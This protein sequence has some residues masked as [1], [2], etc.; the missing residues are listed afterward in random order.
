M[1]EF[2][3]DL[4]AS[5]KLNELKATIEEVRNKISKNEIDLYEEAFKFENLPE[6][7]VIG[8]K[9]PSI[10]TLRNTEKAQLIEKNPE[11]STSRE[12]DRI[13]EKGESLRKRMDKAKH[14][15]DFTKIFELEED[16]IP[17]YDKDISFTDEIDFSDT[18]K[19]AESEKT[20]D[21]PTTLTSNSPEKFITLSPKDEIPTFQLYLLIERASKLL[22]ADGSC[23]DL[24]ISYKIFLNKDKFQT[25]I[26]WNYSE[27]T[28]INYKMLFPLV[29]NDESLSKLYSGI[30]PLEI[31]DKT[32]S[33]DSLL[34][35]VK[36]PLSLFGTALSA[37]LETFTKTVYPFIAIDEYK[38]IN[39]LKTGKDIGYLK[40]LL[41][42]GTPS[43]IN[44]LD[45]T[46]SIDKKFEDSPRKTATFKELN[47]DKKIEKV[48]KIEKIEKVEKIEKIENSAID[49]ID[50]IALFLNQGS[51]KNTLNDSNG[52]KDCKMIDDVSF[53]GGSENKKTEL[54]K[55]YEVKESFEEITLK[56]DEIRLYE[57]QFDDFQEKPPNIKQESTKTNKIQD[58]KIIKQPQISINLQKKSKNELI[59]NLKNALKISHINLEE[60]LKIADKYNLGFLHTLS[61]VNFFEKL[62]L[63]IPSEEI[64]DF[65]TLVVK[66]N[67]LTSTHRRVLFTDLYKILDIVPE[68]VKIQNSL[69]IKIQNMPQQ[70]RPSPYKKVFVKYEKVIEPDLTD[71]NLVKINNLPSQLSVLPNNTILEKS[72]IVEPIKEINKPIEKKVENKIEEKSKEIEKSLEEEDF[73]KIYQK[74]LENMRTLESLTQNFGSWRH[75]KSDSSPAKPALAANYRTNSLKDELLFFS[76][77]IEN[78]QE[79]SSLKQFETRSHERK[80]TDLS[81]YYSSSINNSEK[82]EY[83]SISSLKSTISSADTSKINLYE[84][85]IIPTSIY[86]SSAER[87]FYNEKDSF[88]S[89]LEKSGK[90][91]SPKL[92]KV[93]ENNLK[94]NSLSTELGNISQSLDNPLIQ[95]YEKFKLESFQYPST[96]NIPKNQFELPNYLNSH[97]P[98]ANGTFEYSSAENFQEKEFEIP[99][100][101]SSDY[102]DEA[103][104]EAFEYLS[105]KNF[106][107]NQ[108]GI[109][110]DYQYPTAD[111]TYIETPAIEKIGNHQKSSS[112]N[113]GI[114]EDPGLYNNYKSQSFVEESLPANTNSQ[115]LYKLNYEKGE[116][117]YSPSCLYKNYQDFKNTDQNFSA[118]INENPIKL[119]EFV[120]DFLQKNSSEKETFEDWKSDYKNEVL[121]QTYSEGVSIETEGDSNFYDYKDKNNSFTMAHNRNIST[122]EKKIYKEAEKSISQQISSSRT[123]KPPR[124][125]NLLLD[126][127]I[128]RIA[129]IMKGS[130][131]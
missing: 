75:E 3:D 128:S 8:V 38:P 34:G 23:P 59:Q 32:D 47:Y 28:P 42:V 105:A 90:I 16:A 92:V 125:R 106:Q 2:E 118:E 80:A 19:L 117:E 83:K 54:T 6:K 131:Y 46:Q 120:P 126:P 95:G 44:R 72:A 123:S 5:F 67:P 60:E 89:N 26:F 41:A 81:P 9:P 62:Q 99:H 1:D 14:N 88:S 116:E 55:N 50:D 7:D 114:S 103:T 17:E 30:I 113:F 31:W 70:S 53:Y 86:P 96:E 124:P 52:M 82:E 39:S 15:D 24:F 11:V 94:N 78:T 21:E 101:L 27:N 12:W 98:S 129:A 85:P 58:M 97:C 107:E 87:D 79:N 102:P 91:P 64:Q 56:K 35:L 108:F 61:F 51:L 25:Q 68:P 109:T 74:H 57:R 104:K 43:Q 111:I 65:L 100:Y 115:F 93:E 69:N 127:E 76:K 13:K 112:N 71:E 119:P 84:I 10:F 77:P 33:Q 73:D 122:D 110:P 48:E 4:L 36:L 18:V 121:N 130:K 45:L 22:R 29:V 49:S 37:N 40:V 66:E 20:I 63:E